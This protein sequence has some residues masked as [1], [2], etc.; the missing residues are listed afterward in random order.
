[1]GK[2]DGKV[3]LITGASR[4]I[5]A[6]FARRFAREGAAVAL[7]ART[8]DEG[9]HVLE[10]SINSTLRSI[11]DRGG[12][13]IGIASNL[14]KPEER[15]AL[16]AEVRERLGPVDI[17]INNAAVSFF[18]PILGFPRKRADVMFEVQVFGPMDLAQRVIPD[19]KQRRS[20]WIL[21]ISSGAAEY[22]VG[23]PF[24]EL[25]TTETVYGMVKSALER[26][27]TGLAAELYGTGIAVN[28]LSPRGLVMTPGAKYNKIHELVP[29]SEEAPNVMPEA[30]LALCT[31]DPE[32]LTGRV[33]YSQSFLDE[34][35][36]K[37]QPI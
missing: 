22:P 18:L 33:V 12:K 31:G 26:F 24:Q 37:A 15:E 19:M 17:L 3:A 30:A 32:K 25:H 23:P 20:G 11:E 36:C 35:G 16:V 9:D 1:M 27:T 5:G 6:D 2:L 21:N 34:I 29:D 8:V 28:C 13:A 14:A 7:T 10:G 4:G